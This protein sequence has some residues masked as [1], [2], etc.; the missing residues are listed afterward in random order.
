MFF[1]I[2]KTYSTSLLGVVSG[3]LT[4]LVFIREL[5]HIVPT[6]DFA[7]YAFAFQVVAYLSILQLGLDFATSRE[8][9]LKLGQNNS[10]G[11]YQSYLF[12]RRFNFK[13]SLIGLVLIGICAGLFY[14]GIGVSNKV[15]T[16][17]AAGLILLFGA[18]V[19]ISFLSNPNM[20]ALIGSNKQS[21][22]NINITLLNIAGTIIALVLL[23]TTRLGVYAM[24][25]TL[26]AF[27]TVNF[28]LLRHKAHKFCKDWLIKNK[29]VIV[30]AGYN[31]SILKFS[32]L[33]AIG[34]LAWTIEA[35]S[36]VFILNG[37]GELTLVAFYV[38]WWRFP[39]M[40]FE[41][42]TRLT[43]SSLPSLNTVFGK[44]EPDTKLIFNRLI[45][46]VA[47]IGFCIYVNIA[48]WLPAF[49]NLWVGPQFFIDD[50]QTVSYLI[51]LLIYSRIIGNCFGMFIITIGKVHYSAA[52]C[53]IQAI[54]KTVIA[55]ILVKELG[56][57][58]L[59][60]GSLAA[61]LIQVMGSSVLL[62][63]R[64]YLRPEIV[65]LILIGYAAP[66]VL[67]IFQQ[68]DKVPLLTFLL[69]ASATLIC[70][71]IS[72]ILYILIVS[73]NKKLHFSL[74]PKLF[75]MNLRKQKLHV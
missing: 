57:M 73:L 38:L 2:F 35:T 24:P 41:L 55:I 70:A 27:N 42:A 68:H 32:V 15:D 21:K 61:S 26:V 63:K 4:Q 46:F 71:V 18:S 67:F 12:I 72:W 44:S 50:M 74:S 69:S 66:V 34:G 20:V 31:K 11:A 43:T 6:S 75:L 64:N 37:V 5:A 16:E 65:V 13:I 9:A 22:V 14:N 8:I 36:D 29:P 30:P 54:I 49:I 56:L 62:F 39:Q 7:L 10:Q 1:N 53:W 58:G 51:G 59:F 47:G 25:L 23:K 17:M 52:L 3:L 40:S 60:I 28:F 48:S 45:L 19:F 33:T